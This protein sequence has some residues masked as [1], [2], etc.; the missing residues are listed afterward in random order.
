MY[1]GG[2]SSVFL[3]LC[4]MKPILSILR[5]FYS[6]LYFKLWK[7][8]SQHWQ[9][10]QT[11]LTLKLFPYVYCQVAVCLVLFLHE[12]FGSDLSARLHLQTILSLHSSKRSWIN[13]RA[14][15]ACFKIKVYSFTVDIQQPWFVSM[16]ARSLSM[17]SG[18]PHTFKHC[19]LTDCYVLARRT[20]IENK[21]SRWEKL[22]AVSV[23]GQNTM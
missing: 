3:S 22:P 2:V 10:L 17:S 6:G 7:I 16:P 8:K 19:D 18:F 14:I 20:G 21:I 5:V 9:A 4:K 12:P 1:F 23:D 15:L 11:H 13:E